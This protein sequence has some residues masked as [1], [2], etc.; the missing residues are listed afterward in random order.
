MRRIAAL[1]LIVVAIP[2]PVLAADF[3]EM[4]ERSR[5]ADYNAEQLIVCSTPDGAREAVVRIA[6]IDGVLRV[7]P[8]T[9]DDVEVAAG[10]G[11]WAAT[12]G[13]GVVSAAAVD[14]TSEKKRP[15]Y[16]VEAEEAVTYLGRSAT[17]IVL[18]REGLPRAELV[19]DDETGA[20]VHAVTLTR[21]GDVYCE[22]RFISLEA[23]TT[24]ASEPLTVD[25]D[26]I[27]EAVDWD[28]PSD[29]AGFELLDRYQDE[30]GVRF[31]YYSDGFFSF[32]VFHTASEVALPEAVSV[33]LPSGRY[34]R[35][36]T[37]GQVTYVWE[38]RTGGFALMGDLP[39]DIH[40]EILAEM[41]HPE[42]P[43]FFR[44]FWRSLFG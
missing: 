24:A 37:A 10:S 18:V 38:T 5:Q 6:Q 32:A 19:F 44:R 23:V 35:S 14:T 7:S 33:D 42:D 40:E 13:D 30:D 17:S 21:E 34:N 43:G 41:P 26:E 12:R 29:V 25:P 39:P 27:A 16:Q 4:L 3:D 15:L 22:R 28:L 9:A 20:M 31:A 36:F 1:V 8:V 2:L 11:T